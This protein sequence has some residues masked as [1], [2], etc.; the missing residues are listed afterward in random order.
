MKL[1]K[2]TLILPTGLMKVKFIYLEGACSTTSG[3]AYHHENITPAIFYGGGNILTWAASLQSFRGWWWIFKCIKKFFKEMRECLH[4]NDPK[5]WS[6]STTS[7][8]KKNLNSTFG[9][10]QASSWR[11]TSKRATKMRC[12]KQFWQEEC[13]IISP[14][15]CT[16]LIHRHWR[17]FPP[18]IYSKVSHTVFTSATKLL[19]AVLKVLMCCYI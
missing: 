16:G 7:G 14:E 13:A 17:V 12:A 19:M 9:L 3:T 11:M 5:H 8:F 6:K 10:A 15:Q 1:A 4:I 2:N 18:V